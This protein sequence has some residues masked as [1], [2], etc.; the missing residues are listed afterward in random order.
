MTASVYTRFH[1][2][3]A[4]MRLACIWETADEAAIFSLP[5]CIIL[6]DTGY[7]VIIVAF[8]LQSYSAAMFKRSESFLIRQPVASDTFSLTCE[9]GDTKV[10]EELM[11]EAMARGWTCEKFIGM[12]PFPITDEAAIKSLWDKV[13]DEAGVP[14][15]H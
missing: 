12:F 4:M 11:K 6:V 10:I 15:S 1:A 9:G 2:S 8:N 7:C 5:V 13:L 3:V 14:D